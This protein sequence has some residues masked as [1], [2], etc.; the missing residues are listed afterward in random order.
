MGWRDGELER[1]VN[2]GYWEHVSL[3]LWGI[4]SN[5]KSKIHCVPESEAGE[6]SAIG[7]DMEGQF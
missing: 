6:V 1:V 5:W 3:M 7:E 2:Q 4:S